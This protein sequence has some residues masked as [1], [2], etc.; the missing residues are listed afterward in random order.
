MQFFFITYLPLACSRRRSFG[1]RAF[2]TATTTSGERKL[3]LLVFACQVSARAR[4]C[5]P[6]SVVIHNLTPTRSGDD[7]GDGDGGQVE[8]TR[9]VACAR[10]TTI[11]DEPAEKAR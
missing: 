1:G 8:Q 2:L 3:T 7:G 5:A 6:E 9:D 10:S 11:L 4:S